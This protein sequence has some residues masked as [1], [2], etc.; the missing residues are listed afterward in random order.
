MDRVT[1]LLLDTVKQALAESQEQR[2]FRSGK[3]PGLFPSR[4]GSSGEAARRAVQDGLLEVI[5][6]ETRGKLLIEWV[7]PTGRAVDFVHAHESPSAAL[8]ELQTVLAATHQGLPS[9]LGQLQA[10]LDELAAQF[11]A[12]VQAMGQ[13]LD[14]LQRRVEEAIARIEASQPQVSE[15]LADLV[16]WANE[17][18]LYLERRLETGGETPCPLSELFSALRS[19]HPELTVFE[20]H[21]GLRRLHDR[22]ILR[23][24]P[25]ESV[26]GLPE[27][28]YALLDGVTTYYYAVRAAG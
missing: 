18:L 9:W 13:R 8:K 10:R 24:L 19:S 14:T 20:F 12:E 1:T 5:R 2:L 17:M 26:Q 11:G 7:R 3:L 16:P 28:E 25:F 4:S 27:P 6:T 21:A 15:R 23:L 22:G